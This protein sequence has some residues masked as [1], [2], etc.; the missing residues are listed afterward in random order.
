MQA[1]A[2]FSHRSVMFARCIAAPI[3]NIPTFER[4]KCKDV[5]YE[6]QLML[7][8]LCNGGVN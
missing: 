2:M 7:R 8:V 3:T 5:P 1:L 4:G 6:R